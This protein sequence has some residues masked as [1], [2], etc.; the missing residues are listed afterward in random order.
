MFFQT[1]QNSPSSYT[2]RAR[3]RQRPRSG[4]NIMEVPHESGLRIGRL[5]FFGVVYRRQSFSALCPDRSR[6]RSRSGGC[7]GDS[8]RAVDPRPKRRMPPGVLLTPWPEQASCVAPDG[9]M[10]CAPSSDIEPTELEHPR[11]APKH[12]REKTPVLENE[13]QPRRKPSP[14]GG[15]MPG[16][17][18][19]SDR[20][21]F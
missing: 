3:L 1:W 16:L 19:L 18:T 7:V 20:G 10:V 21:G 2:D 11:G 14:S 4:P 17:Q 6:G 5:G 9:L 13:C 15:R 12:E 8:L